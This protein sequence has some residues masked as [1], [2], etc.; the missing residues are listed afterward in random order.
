M[1][2]NAR[3][4]PHQSDALGTGQEDAV[5]V[6]DSFG[7]AIGHQL[8]SGRWCSVPFVALRMSSAQLAHEVLPFFSSRGMRSWISCMSG[9]VVLG[10]GMV[11]KPPALPSDFGPHCESGIRG[12]LRSITPGCSKLGSMQRA[13]FAPHCQNVAI[14]RKTCPQPRKFSPPK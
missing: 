9:N 1:L 10:L 11:P 3:F 12:K 5:S 14:A 6:Q 13:N 4:I 2:E 8:G 7:K